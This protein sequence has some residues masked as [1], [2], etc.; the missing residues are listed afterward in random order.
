MP[1]YENDQNQEMK[2]Y[3]SNGQTAVFAA[4]E[5]KSVNFYSNTDGFTKTS[6]EPYVNRVAARETVTLS[7]TA[8]TVT[9]DLNISEVVIVKISDSVNVFLQSESNTPAELSNWTSEDPVVVIPAK[10][11]FTQLQLTGSGTCD[12]V[13]YRW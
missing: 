3:G 7:E 12:V 10:G 6:D 5:E 9:V 4:N 13:Q 8:E 2:L 11:N 1:T